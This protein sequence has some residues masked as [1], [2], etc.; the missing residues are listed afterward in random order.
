MGTHPIFESDFDCLTV[1]RNHIIMLAVR[2]QLIHLPSRTLATSAVVPAKQN[3]V[4]R[5]YPIKREVGRAKLFD[6]KV[7]YFT[8]K[9][10]DV[11]N[12]I[13]SSS[14]WPMTFGLACCAVEMMH[15]AAPRYD[16]DRFGVV[17]R[18]TPRQSDL[19]IVAGT[20]TNKMAP[21]L[22]RVYDQMP[23]PRYVLSMGSCANGG[24]YYH[25][26]PRR[27]SHR[28]RRCLRP[29]LPAIGRGAAL[30]NFAAPEKNPSRKQRASLVPQSIVAH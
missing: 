13:R 18:A 26:S 27:R 16:M 14:L 23:A 1:F 7:E 28:P 17:F 15:F 12:Y 22:R 6:N 20:L 29:R 25:Y 19:M 30:W 2:R 3:E 21:A 8:T 9:L 5:G 10:D 24:G 11:A 4:E